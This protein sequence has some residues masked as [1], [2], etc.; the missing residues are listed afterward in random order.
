ME[1]IL[2]IGELLLTLNTLRPNGALSSISSLEYIIKQVREIR[3]IRNFIDDCR[4]R[5]HLM[6]RSRIMAH[7]NNGFFPLTLKYLGTHYTDMKAAGL[8]SKV[9]SVDASN[10]F[11]YEDIDFSDMNIEVRANEEDAARMFESLVP[12]SLQLDRLFKANLRTSEQYKHNRNPY[13]MSVLMGWY[14]KTTDSSEVYL[15]SDP[16]LA[17]SLTAHFR[18]VGSEDYTG[19]AFLEEFVESKTLVPFG[20]RIPDGILL[21]KMTL[22]FMM[23]YIYAQ[24]VPPYFIRTAGYSSAL[25]AYTTSRSNLFVNWLEERLRYA[26]LAVP[27][28]NQ[29]FAADGERHEYDLIIV[30]ESDKTILLVEAKYRNVAQ[31]SVTGINLVKNELEGKRGLIYEAVRHDKRLAFFEMHTDKFEPHLCLVHD[32]DMYQVKALIVTKST[33]ILSRLDRVELVEAMD[34]LSLSTGRDAS[35]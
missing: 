27:I 4:T 1:A 10:L 3:I 21:D 23:I 8:V 16:E 6:V 12:T 33:P 35:S 9:P 22:L 2:S 11:L 18:Q 29:E 15:E 19:E 28:K 5:R 34:F 31:S 30:D 24:P 20:V 25:N 7:E 17:A 32:V 13:A 14:L 26:G